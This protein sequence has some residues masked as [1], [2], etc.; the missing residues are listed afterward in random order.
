MSDQN[1]VLVAYLHPDTVSHSFMDSL[2]RVSEHEEDRGTPLVGR[3]AVR[4]G[5][6]SI[7][8]ARNTCVK[9]FLE[10]DAEW[11]W[12]VDSDM[13]FASDALE[14]LLAAADPNTAPVV[15]AFCFAQLSG[16]SDGMGGFHRKHIPTLYQWAQT[17]R[18][19]GLTLRA[20]VEYP[21]SALVRVGGTGAACLLIHRSVLERMGHSWFTRKMH[22]GLLAGEDISFCY[23]LD[24]MNVPIYVHTGVKTSHFKSV[25]VQ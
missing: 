14:M 15:G 10:T 21:D 2:W 22:N 5:P 3:F 8:E 11:L 25:F 12:T 4:S 24:Q 7:P 9:A 16:E 19:S 20:D 13:G 18:G 17:A 23:R 1:G 6:M